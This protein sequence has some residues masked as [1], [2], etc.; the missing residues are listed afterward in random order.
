MSAGGYLPRR[1]GK[2]TSKP[3]EGG[4][5]VGTMFRATK[6]CRSR[7]PNPREN[8]S[9]STGPQARAGYD[10]KPKRRARASGDRPAPVPKELGLWALSTG[11]TGVDRFSLLLWSPCGS[12]GVPSCGGALGAGVHLDEQRQE[13]VRMASPGRQHLQCPYAGTSLV[14]KSFSFFSFAATTD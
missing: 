7:G 5:V 2:V 4:G 8:S 10:L 1:G 11:V 3:G 13:S 14:P 6:T 9:Q 12:R